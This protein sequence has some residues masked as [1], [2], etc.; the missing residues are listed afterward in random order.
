MEINLN[1]DLSAVLKRLAESGK[2]VL[3]ACKHSCPEKFELG[4]SDGVGGSSSVQP[5]IDRLP[6]GSRR[7][8]FSVLP[9]RSPDNRDSDLEIK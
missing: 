1:A 4:P 2:K 8:S 7:S 3:H 6:R 9:V 5:Y